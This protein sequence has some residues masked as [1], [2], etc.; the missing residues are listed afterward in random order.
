MH[1]V[2]RSLQFPIEEFEYQPEP[3]TVSGF[4]AGMSQRVDE[5]LAAAHWQP[6]IE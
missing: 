4:I 6:L 2:K 3:G 5:L 1:D